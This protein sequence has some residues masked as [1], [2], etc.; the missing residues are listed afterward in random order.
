MTMKKADKLIDRYVKEFHADVT[1]RDVRKEMMCDLGLISMGL[2]FI[3]K[4]DVP[5]EYVRV[6]HE[7]DLTPV[8][9][10][11]ETWLA[12]T[13][14]GIMSP[15]PPPARAAAVERPLAAIVVQQPPAAVVQQ[16][17]AV[18]PPPV[19]SAGAREAMDRIAKANEAKLIADAERAEA[20]AVRAVAEAEAAK[21]LAR[22]AEAVKHHATDLA[23]AAEAKQIE[24]A[25]KIAAQVAAKEAEAKP[26]TATPAVK[27]DVAEAA[28]TTAKPTA[29]A[30]GAAVPVNRKR[31]RDDDGAFAAFRTLSLEDAPPTIGENVRD[32]PVEAPPTRPAPAVDPPPT[33]GENVIDALAPVCSFLLKRFKM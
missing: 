16:P 30:G 1:R 29:G 11:F 6:V 10:G 22:K 18:E 26:L 24:V 32:R 15:P 19:M 9:I 27:T 2:D 28:E 21:Q 33:I 4:S 17:P 5:T 7:E 3:R 25:E 23:N 8:Q 31:M 12:A 13:F 14:P 20:D